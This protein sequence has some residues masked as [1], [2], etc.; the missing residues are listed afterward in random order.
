M[1]TDQ[2]SFE[3]KDYEYGFTTD[4]ESEVFPK[5][6]NEE[7]ISRLSKKK[8]NHPSCLISD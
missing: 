8:M 7:I 3:K 1:A 5:G 2:I 6:L 4:I